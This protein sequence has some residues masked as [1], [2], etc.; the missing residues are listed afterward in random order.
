MGGKEND[1]VFVSLT[2]GIRTHI[3]GGYFLLGFE[4]PVTGPDTFENRVTF[5]YIRGF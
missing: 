4:V 5:M 2:P 1:N 3:S